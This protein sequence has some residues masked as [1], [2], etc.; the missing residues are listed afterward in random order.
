MPRTQ[1]PEVQAAFEVQAAPL[2]SWPP[3][4]PQGS[5]SAFFAVHAAPL[6]KYPPVHWA[7]VTQE[8]LHVEVPLQTYGL[9]EG[10]PGDPP[11]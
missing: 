9:Q 11:G 8:L 3:P 1:K 2:G 7:S 6:Q 4:P 5:P 10:V